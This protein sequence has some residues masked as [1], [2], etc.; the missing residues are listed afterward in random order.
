MCAVRTEIN[1]AVRLRS[2]TTE[3]SVDEIDCAIWEAARATSAASSFFSH[4]DIE[5]QRFTDGATEC[6]NP[7]EHLLEEAVDIW[8]G[9][10]NRLACI[11][12]IGTGKPKLEAFGKNLIEIGK[13]LIRISTDAERMVDQFQRLSHSRGFEDIYYRFNV[14][15]GLEDV[16][17]ESYDQQGKIWAAAHHYLNDYVV[18]QQCKAL[19][20]SFQST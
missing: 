3:A 14:S 15:Q 5:G 4:I 17:L 7:I 11:V 8:P 2:Y 10:Q 6:N 12:S 20:T 16:G 19:A 9:A 13:T 18:K 1:K